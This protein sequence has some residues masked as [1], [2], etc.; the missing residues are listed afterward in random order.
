MKSIV[1]IGAGDLGKEVVWLIEDIN[2]EKPTYLILGFLDDDEQK[3][4]KE[5]CW[6]KV[7]GGVNQLE[8]LSEKTP[9]YAVIAVKNGEAR[10]KIAEM[11]PAFTKWESIIHPRATVASSSTIGEGCILFPNVTISV[12]SRLG[13]FGVYHTQATIGNDCT[14]GDYVSA[15]VGA[16]VMGHTKIGNGMIIDPCT[17]IKQNNEIAENNTIESKPQSRQDHKEDDN[18]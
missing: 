2:R 14:I 18:G 17:C 4:G 16:T 1:I 5:Y 8:K 7:I 11:Y 13:R 9:L 15:M 6:Y 10:Q 12:D 3:L